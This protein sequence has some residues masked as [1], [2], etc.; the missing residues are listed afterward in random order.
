MSTVAGV[1]RGVVAGLPVKAR[2]DRVV[3]SCLA[4]DAVSGGG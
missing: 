1:G 2:Q 3:A 4:I